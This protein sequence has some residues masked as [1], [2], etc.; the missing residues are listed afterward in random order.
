[1]PGATN[2]FLA[3]IA[4]PHLS[5]VVGRLLLLVYIA[6]AVPIRITFQLPLRPSPSNSTSNWTELPSKLPMWTWLSVDWWVYQIFDSK[7][8]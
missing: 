4:K 7:R 3:H 5:F 6:V 2:E 8:H 1:M